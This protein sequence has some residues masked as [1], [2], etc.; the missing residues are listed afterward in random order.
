MI[1]AINK[2]MK[3]QKGFTLVELIVVIAIIGILGAIAVPRF[4][5]F[6]ENAAL[7]A[8]RATAAVIGNAANLHYMDHPDEDTIDIEDDLVNNGLL[9]S[10][11]KPQGQADDEDEKE[12]FY[13]KI[14]E[15]NISVHYDDEDGTQ[16]YPVT[17]E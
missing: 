16:L 10:E 4:S 17:A 14:D 8:D 3:N 11:P 15:G 6:R 9:E 2:R 7:K 13:V 5:G 12:G 1:K